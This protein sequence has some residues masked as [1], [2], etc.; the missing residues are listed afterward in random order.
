MT[1]L[2]SS[3]IK[4]IKICIISPL[5]EILSN[6]LY[7][8]SFFL[9]AFQILGPNRYLS[10][11][12]KNSLISRF[13]HESDFKSISS[14]EAFL[15]YVD[16]LVKQFYNYYPK[17]GVPIMIP[18]GDIRIQK[19]ANRPELCSEELIK[20][21]R[22]DDY[23]CTRE[24]LNNI[25]K[26][27][28]CGY[29]NTKKYYRVY[30]K[31]D[32]Y[33][34]KF[35]KLTKRF[36]G[37][38]STYNLIT[39]GLNLD[40]NIDDYQEKK[41]EIIEFVKD[42]DLK[43]LTIQL[44]IYFP[45][46]DD[47]ALVLMGVEM[48]NYFLYPYT[49]FTSTI[50]THFNFKDSYFI[51]VFILFVIAVSFQII[52]FT[53]EVSLR[54]EMEIH[55]F[56]FLNHV[57]NLLLIIFVAFYFYAST[58]ENYFNDSFMLKEFHQHLVTISLKSYCV[59]IISVLFFS[60]PF[61]FISMIA[62]YQKGTVQ[63]T[64]Y[65]K[66]LFRT[67]PGVLL[68]SFIALL[69]ILMF[70]LMNFFLFNSKFYILKN[71]FLSFCSVFNFELINTMNRDRGLEFSVSD[72]REELVFP[73]I[74]MIIMILFFCLIFA[75]SSNLL[76]QASEYEKKKEENIILSKIKDLDEKIGSDE[77]SENEDLYGSIKKKILWLGLIPK[78]ENFNSLMNKNKSLLF[79]QSGN[80]VES[81]LKY[82]FAIKPNMQYQ[83]LK[84]KI[85]IVIEC[86]AENNY[87]T[88]RDLEQI[89][90]LL[91]WLEFS[92]CK[93]NILLY[94]QNRLARELRM[95]LSRVY[96]MIR[97]VSSLL[98][99]EK[100]V[101]PNDDSDSE[102]EENVN[103]YSITKAESFMLYPFKMYSNLNSSYYSLRKRNKNKSTTHKSKDS[104]LKAIKTLKK[105]DTMR[106]NNMT[107]TGENKD[108]KRM[109]SGVSSSTTEEKV[110]KTFLKSNT[111]FQPKSFARN[112]SI[113]SQINQ[114]ITEED[115]D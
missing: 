26:N 37:K 25:Y 17:N 23:Q 42:Y 91:K 52:R 1:I 15:S 70:C 63:L 6:F 109:L 18:F 103:G 101:N 45:T 75:T 39:E 14:D 33:Y 107:Y 72:S 89:N 82:L 65:M 77:D 110:K 112:N 48:I 83:N 90:N 22:C 59:I 66:I 111:L 3:K 29:P 94:T 16:F 60:I 19:F 11:Y 88:E 92:G 58:E 53:Y 27:T 80:K 56:V 35:R 51:A 61:R 64:Q 108:Y 5:F 21:E 24:T 43:F 36:E 100:F 31:L 97:C 69:M 106:D 81:F 49:I 57:I 54:F 96:D 76:E 102:E 93:L 113:L 85:G 95:K 71:M 105:E 46:E 8:V 98:E 34:S 20:V 9:L 12:K 99:L 74:Q 4:Y 79:F 10:N 2:P 104:S 67:L 13:F 115:K 87:L 28:F 32:I 86:Q 41:Q 47:Y 68:L 7:I 62:W 50:Y 44:N 84:E 78:K 40:F 55:T 73:V 30:D 114:P 38:Y